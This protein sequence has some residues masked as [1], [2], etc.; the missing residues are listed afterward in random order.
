MTSERRDEGLRIGPRLTIPASELAV[1]TSRSG[2]PGGQNV[3]KVETRVTLRYAPATSRVLTPVQRERILDALASRL[4]GQG[5]LVVHASR[6]RSQPRNLADARERLA[7]LIRG[8]LAPRKPR[9]ATRPTRASKERR[10][11]EKRRRAR[12]KLDRR[13]DASEGG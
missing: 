6:F 13:R 12:R 9:R 4:T 7:E 3:N 1:E 11:A 5:E 8:A 2:G 10:L